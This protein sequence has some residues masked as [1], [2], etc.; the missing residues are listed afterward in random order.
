[1]DGTA[2]N[3]VQT[4]AAARTIA[5]NVGLKVFH[6]VPGVAE[7]LG[8]EFDGY[9]FVGASFSIALASQSISGV[10]FR[11][12]T[13]TGIGTGA[14]MPIFDSCRFGAVTLPPSHCTNCGLEGT[15]TIGTAGTFFFDNCHSGVA[16]TS[17]PVLDFGSALNS[18]DVNFR[19]YSGGIEIQNMGAGT[20]S[21]N[22]SLEGW[23]QLII[24]A[25]CSATATVAIRGH[26]SVT[27]NAGGAV[28]L[29]DAVR[30]D[31]NTKKRGGYAQ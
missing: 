30:F 10:L 3:P 18:S 26:F 15:F 28:T 27:D 4:L 25:N 16:G 21:Y 1:M 29:S 7:T 19:R 24:N 31:E 12:A 11:G 17:T 20:G 5:D 9:E 6:C 22:M 14:T 2:D 13:V 8:E 23:G